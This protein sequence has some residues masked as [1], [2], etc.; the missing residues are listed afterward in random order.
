MLCICSGACGADPVLVNRKN[1]CMTACAR[2]PCN[3]QRGFFYEYLSFQAHAVSASTLPLFAIWIFLK[4]NAWLRFSWHVFRH[5]ERT[6]PVILIRIDL[7]HETHAHM[8]DLRL[9][10]KNMP[11]DVSSSSIFYRHI[12]I[13]PCSDA[14]RGLRYQ[15]F[16]Q[17]M[18]TKQPVHCS[19]CHPQFTR[20]NCHS[21]IE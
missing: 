16:T 17:D 20:P 9:R 15:Y 10:N 19:Q 12:P 6:G 7:T 13:L 4:A 11:S 2:T 14:L 1:L 18:V 8:Q 3:P 21:V 5:F